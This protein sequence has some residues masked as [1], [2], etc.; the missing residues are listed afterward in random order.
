M[1]LLLLS[2]VTC[3]AII[4]KFT[5]ISLIGSSFITKNVLIE[6]LPEMSTLQRF[7]KPKIDSLAIDAKCLLSI[8]PL[9]WRHRCFLGIFFLFSLTLIATATLPKDWLS[10]EINWPNL[11]FFLPRVT[12]HSAAE[13]IRQVWPEVSAVWTVQLPWK[14]MLDSRTWHQ[15]LVAK[16]AHNMCQFETK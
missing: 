14:S 5:E 8:S 10:G 11:C 12:W 15:L 13:E 3:R 9:Y 6:V 2:N 7:T 1:R 4:R 16:L